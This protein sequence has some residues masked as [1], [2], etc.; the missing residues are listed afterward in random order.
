MGPVPR[1]RGARKARTRVVPLGPAQWRPPAPVRR[2]RKVQRVCSEPRNSEVRHS[3]CACRPGEGGKWSGVTCRAALRF[4]VLLLR[5]KLGPVRSTFDQN[6]D[7]HIRPSTKP[8]LARS[9]KTRERVMRI[10]APFA[11]LFPGF[12]GITRSE[13]G[14]PMSLCAFELRFPIPT[15]GPLPLS[16]HFLPCPISFGAC[17]GTIHQGAS[18]AGPSGRSRASTR[19]KT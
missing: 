13:P 8:G 6:S 15:P 4:E 2:R 12:G 18:R 16:T 5:P 17:K 7:S 14:D 3:P 11:G 1:A 9:T 19:E 10:G